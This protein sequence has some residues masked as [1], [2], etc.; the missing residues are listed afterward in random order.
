MWWPP[1]AATV[2]ESDDCCL[3]TP[4]LLLR[5]TMKAFEV[6]SHANHLLCR[7]LKKS[8]AFGFAYIVVFLFSFF[9]C[10]WG[11][12]L[13]P[14]CE[15]F[16]NSSHMLSIWPFP[17]PNYLALTSN[18]ISGQSESYWWG[19]HSSVCL[20]GVIYLFSRPKITLINLLM[21]IVSHLNGFFFSFF[22]WRDAWFL[23]LTDGEHQSIRAGF[24]DI[25][26]SFSVLKPHH[27]H[28]LLLFL[29][30]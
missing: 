15:S 3:W 13:L 20:C 6:I 30:V 7:H 12:H 2:E 29:Q 25:F 10:H 17:L 1:K 23:S 27:I 24:I 4:G 21:Q 18:I 22:E 11:I 28:L 26:I 8:R 5:P 19:L 16:P 14:V 9:F